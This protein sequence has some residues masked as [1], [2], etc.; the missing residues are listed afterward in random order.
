MPL[1]GEGYF[2][3]LPLGKRETGVLLQVK[4]LYIKLYGPPKVL[5]YYKI[6]KISTG[7]ICSSQSLVTLCYEFANMRDGRGEAHPIL[8][9][10]FCRAPDWFSVDWY[11]VVCVAWGAGWWTGRNDKQKKQY[12]PVSGWLEAHC[13]RQLHCEPRHRNH[14]QERK[15]L[16]LRI[17]RDCLECWDDAGGSWGATAAVRCW[18]AILACLASWTCCHWAKALGQS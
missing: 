6:K 14:R 15:K 2:I 3:L 10:F 7:L 18:Q 12:L 17:H 9:P 4:S 11:W 5:G 13:K 8:L 1:Q 16:Y